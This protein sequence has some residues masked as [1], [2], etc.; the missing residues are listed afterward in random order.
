MAAADEALNPGGGSAETPAFLHE[1]EVRFR[2]LDPMGHVHHSLPLIYFEEAR[3]AF[4]RR[5]VGSPALEAIEYVIA[6]CH[7]RYRARVHYPGHATVTVSV[8]KVGTRSFELSYELRGAGGLLA[9]GR[10]AQVMYDYRARRPTEIP[11]EVR[12]RLAAHLPPGA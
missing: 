2:D 7:I 11:I 8:T 6:E 5:L 9:E 10:T 3:A 1:V 12:G 4:W